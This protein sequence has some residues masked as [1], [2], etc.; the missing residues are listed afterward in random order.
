M[1]VI[2]LGCA[3]IHM[4]DAID[5]IKENP[6]VKIVGVWDHDPQRAMYWAE[7]LDTT[8]L[9]YPDVS[10]AD[11]VI[12]MSETSLHLELVKVATDA[13]KPLFVEKP[14]AVSYKE[15]QQ[16]SKMITQAGVLFHTGY[17]MREIEALK[18]LRSLVQ[19]KGFGKVVRA[20]ALFA[21]NGLPSGWFSDY[22]WMFIKK[23]VGYGG[24]GDLG[25]HLVDLLTWTLG[26]PVSSVSSILFRSTPGLEVDDGGEAL[27]LLQDGT[28]ASIGV[29]LT[30]RSAP[31]ELL[32]TG[33]DGY[34]TIR[35]DLL[36]VETISE[37][38]RLPLQRLSA[39]K[40]VQ[41]FLAVLG[42][43]SIATL[44]STEEA[45]QHCAVLE[46]CYQAAS[47]NTWVNVTTKTQDSLAGSYNYHD[48]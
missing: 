34:A 29:G 4:K 14:L 48:C 17:F 21:H 44:V 19:R 30:E 9:P 40:G 1:Q 42:G 23:D 12:I 11:A 37:S 36:T 47:Q 16:I 43:E 25:V 31:F 26:S 18:Q 7:K 8:Q 10:G 27:F 15:A 22:S 46:A 13:G 24:F 20:R 6:E 32:V 35:D 33:T 41:R 5:A 38:F 3:H 2:F 28:T 39:A 45:A